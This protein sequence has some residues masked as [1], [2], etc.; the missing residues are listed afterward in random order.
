MPE[1]IR[2]GFGGYFRTDPEAPHVLNGA[3][4]GFTLAE[5]LNWKP[6]IL[7]ET[8]VETED[9]TVVTSNVQKCSL[10]YA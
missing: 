1:I 8:T 6:E 10:E 4:L 7:Q 5:V 2:P 9:G 3:F